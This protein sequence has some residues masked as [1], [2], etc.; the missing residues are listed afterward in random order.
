[1]YVYAERGMQRKADTPPRGNGASESICE[2]RQS[3]PNDP[4]IFQAEPWSAGKNT[5]KKHKCDL[6]TKF[7]PYSHLLSIWCVYGANLVCGSHL[8]FYSVDHSSVD[9]I[10]GSQYPNLFLP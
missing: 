4:P 10:N 7:A 9:I 1:M 8:C 6:H 2:P 5:L 3:E